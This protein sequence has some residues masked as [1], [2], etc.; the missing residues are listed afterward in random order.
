MADYLP[1]DLSYKND[2]TKILSWSVI[3]CRKGE[4]DS[5]YSDLQCSICKAVVSFNIINDT[6]V[7]LGRETHLSE[8]C[9]NYYRPDPVFDNEP[10]AAALLLASSLN[11]S[12][13]LGGMFSS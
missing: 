3:N 10:I 1:I 11:E 5:I 9:K 4:D 12:S 7:L 6:E 2:A 8:E 13:S